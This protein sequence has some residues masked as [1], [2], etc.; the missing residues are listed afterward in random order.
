MAGRDSG[1]SATGYR[2]GSDGTRRGRRQRKE[3]ARLLEVKTLDA[4]AQSAE[5]EVTRRFYENRGF[6][7]LESIDPFPGW[8]PGNP[9]AIYVKVLEL[10]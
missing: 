5:Y 9:C 3:G 8:E 7:L 1:V 10:R 6:E 4:S 2:H